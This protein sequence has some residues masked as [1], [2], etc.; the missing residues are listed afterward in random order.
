MFRWVLSGRHR[1]A[2]Q[3][4]IYLAIAPLDDKRNFVHC[5]IFRCSRRKAAADTSSAK[6]ARMDRKAESP[7]AGLKILAPGNKATTTPV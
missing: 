1:A 2:L 5:T 7:L 3:H 4:K 6:P